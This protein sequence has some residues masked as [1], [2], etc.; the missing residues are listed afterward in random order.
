MSALLLPVALLAAAAAPFQPSMEA[1]VQK[2]A[3]DSLRQK[4]EIAASLV[5]YRNAVAIEPGWA[6]AHEAL[7][8]AH[9]AARA[10]PASAEAFGRAVEIDPGYALAWYNLGHVSRK[11]GALDRA[12]TAYE[13]Y[14][15]LAPADP[16]GRLALADT[17]AGLGDGPGAAREYATYLEL[18][19]A[20]PERA[21]DVARARA[22]LA[23]LPPPG[24]AAARPP[25]PAGAVASAAHAPAA[26]APAIPA[27]PSTAPAVPAAPSA[28]VRQGVADKLALGDRLAAGGDHR[29]ALF[30]YQDAVYLDPRNVG[31]RVRLGRAY[32]ALRYPEQ[33]MEQYAQA[34]AVD[35]NDAEARRAMEEARKVSP[36]AAVAPVP[37]P[38]A[39]AVVVPAP[40]SASPAPVAA[41]AAAGTTAAGAGGTGAAVTS[42]SL[43]RVYRLPEGQAAGGPMQAPQPVGP[44]SEPTLVVTASP[45][46]PPVEAAP[47]GPS[48]RDR[49]KAAVG[50]MASREYAQAIA[51]LDEAI[52]QDPGMGVAFAARASAR[53]GL[54]KYREAAD[55]YRTALDRAPQLA[56]PLYGLGECHRILGEPAAASDYYARYAQ[57]GAAD[58]REDL[59]DVARNRAAELGR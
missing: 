16:D 22:A 31:A 36:A 10:Y 6:E 37:A 46:A 47:Q 24:P 4:G 42:S 9:Y 51:E 50:L 20:A 27:A 48:A 2:A 45:E 17:L 39:R 32:A 13:R 35:P 58:V 30:A 40:A 43:P 56:T 21:A 15:T 14:A 23:S 28:A 44:D 59:R 53:F 11:T 12:R 25:A 54:G 8:E 41:V 57:S 34:V 33:A 7:G 18:A 3:G 26:A 55:D 1:R 5:A 29:G 19:G 52:R 49:Y 38:A